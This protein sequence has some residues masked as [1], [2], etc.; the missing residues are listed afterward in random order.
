MAL[1][2]RAVLK[3]RRAAGLSDHP[4]FWAAFVAE[5]GWR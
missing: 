1:A 2:M 4:Y 3:Q 5:G